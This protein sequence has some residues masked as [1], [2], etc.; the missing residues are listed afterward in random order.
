MNGLV[1]S[2]SP[3]SAGSLVQLT[4]SLVVVV[5]VILAASWLLKRFKVPGVRGGIGALSVIDQL[6]LGP[7]E[8]I[9]LVRGG[10][11]QVLVGIGAGGVV[12]LTPLATPIA[13]PA[14]PVAQPGFAE[15]LREMMKRQGPSE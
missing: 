7:R 6:V 8:R 9:V 2:A 1:H 11:G 3:V 14:A 15:R 12:A 10:E 13:L 5:G 4:L